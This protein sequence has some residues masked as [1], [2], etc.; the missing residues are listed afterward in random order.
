VSP[1]DLFLCS[2]SALSLGVHSITELV[3]EGI[4]QHPQCQERQ[5]LFHCFEKNGRVGK[6]GHFLIMDR[7][8]FGTLKARDFLD[9]VLTSVNSELTTSNPRTILPLAP[10]ARAE[11][12]A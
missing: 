4:E 11:P 6:V 2:H 8:L 9:F 12:M 3:K 7:P 1:A 10:G 5:I